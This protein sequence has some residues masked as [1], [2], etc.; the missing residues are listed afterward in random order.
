M[1][2]ERLKVPIE[3]LTRVCD[4]DSLGFETTSDV[5]PLQGTIAQERAMSALELGLGINDDGFNIFVS[6][7]PGSGRNVG[8]PRT[9]G[10]HCGR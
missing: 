8:A 5:S 2:V 1:S 9:S 3:C 4:P 6:G 10:A 7:A